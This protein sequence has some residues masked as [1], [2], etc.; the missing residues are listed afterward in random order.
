M[1]RPPAI[2]RKDGGCNKNARGDR[3]QEMLAR[4]IVTCHR[5][6]ERFRDLARKLWQSP[7]PQAIDAADLPKAA[8]PTHCR[9]HFHPVRAPSPPFCKI[10]WGAIR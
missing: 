7:T 9:Y 1:L 6:G 2:M 3:I 4:L 8:G 10:I 5:G